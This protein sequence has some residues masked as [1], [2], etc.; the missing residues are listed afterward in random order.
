MYYVLLSYQ[1]PASAVVDEI[2]L[3]AQKAAGRFVAAVNLLQPGG[4]FVVRKPGGDRLVVSDGPLAHTPAP[5]TA[6]YVLDCLDRAEA[7]A[8]ARE[9]QATHQDRGGVE[10]RPLFDLPAAVAGR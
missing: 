6:M 1:D 8:L 5:L 7:E 4:A 10:V 3:E 2:F 9:L